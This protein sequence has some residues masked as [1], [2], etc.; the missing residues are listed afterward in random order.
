MTPRSV[1]T[2]VVLAAGAVCAAAQPKLPLEIICEGVYQSHVQGLASDRESAIF[3]SFT[4]DLVKTDLTGK[5]LKSVK[6]QTHHGDL[7]YLDGKLYVAW[8][9]LFNRPGADSKV[10]VYD[11]RD[12]TLLTVKKIPEVTFGAGAMESHNGHFFVV[13]GLPKDLDENH[14]YEYDLDLTFV[15]RHVIASGYTRMGI[16]AVGRWRGHWWFGC[17]GGDLLKTDD[18]FGLTGKYRTSWPYGIV[19]WDDDTFLLGVHFG[20]RGAC[21]G[22]AVRARLDPERGLVKAMP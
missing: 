19:G 20:K 3:W 5:V 10:Y 14:V 13:G 6:V 9:N 16:Q 2:G 7:T 15:K 1:A 8:S 4:R 12:L 17:Y 21:R 18:G 11:A 22:K